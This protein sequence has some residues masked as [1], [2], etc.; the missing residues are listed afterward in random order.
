[1]VS[2]ILGG[3]GVVGKPLIRFH[4]CVMG[5]VSARVATCVRSCGPGSAEGAGILAGMLCIV[6]PAVWRS[7]S[8]ALLIGVSSILCWLCWRGGLMEGVTGGV[9]SG[10]E[11]GA[12]GGGALAAARAS[13]CS[14][15]SRSALVH[16]SSSQFCAGDSHG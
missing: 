9:G 13:C 5:L 1:M 4:D 10:V 15:C 7:V 16:G 3:E 8:K 14:A 2:G 12:G 11:L 6:D